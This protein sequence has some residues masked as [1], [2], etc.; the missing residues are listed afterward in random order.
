MQTFNKIPGMALES[1][2]VQ[3]SFY[4]DTA[5]QPNP[6]YYIME[7]FKDISSYEGRY[8]ISN[9]GKV[10]SLTRYVRHYAG[11]EKIIKERLLKQFDR[12]KGYYFVRLCKH[13]IVKNYLIHRLVATAFISNL[14][15]KPEINH[16][17]GIRH[18]NKVGNLEW[19]TRSENVLYSFRVLG[20]I[21]SQRKRVVQYDLNGNMLNIFESATAA[22][23]FING[24][25][26]SIS[27]NCRGETKTVYGFKYKYKLKSEL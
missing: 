8:R 2:T 13:G 12:G 25:Q 19:A 1:E 14:E 21:S 23:K 5:E 3:G 16:K 24:F 6:G 4:V 18:D 9:L 10:K 26:G 15:N 11:G 7:I 17:N 27:R 20:V 22:A